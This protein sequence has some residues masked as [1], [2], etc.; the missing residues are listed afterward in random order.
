MEQGGIQ[1]PQ[2]CVHGW[3]LLL[4]L[5]A[6]WWQVAG[7][8]GV[9]RAGLHRWGIALRGHTVGLCWRAA[10]RH[11]GVHGCGDVLAAGMAGGPRVI[12]GMG[13]V[14]G[15]I[16]AVAGLAGTHLFRASAKLHGQRDGSGERRPW[17]TSHPPSL[18]PFSLF[19]IV[20]Y[21]PPPTELFLSASSQSIPNTPSI[22]PLDI[23]TL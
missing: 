5:G 3:M 12:A 7:C 21:P 8:I 6:R 13:A 20:L 16:L 9:L 11:A 23:P 1:G 17:C 10:W 18:P 15:G 14:A 19:N 2:S 22:Y 4:E